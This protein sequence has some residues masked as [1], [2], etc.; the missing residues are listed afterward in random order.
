MEFVCLQSSSKI[1]LQLLPPSSCCSSCSFLPA[2]S[3]G[4]LTRPFLTPSLSVIGDDALFPLS[5]ESCNLSLFLSLPSPR[6]FYFS[7]FAVSYF[8]GI[9]T[10][11]LSLSLSLVLH[12]LPPWIFF[13]VYFRLLFEFFH[14]LSLVLQVNC[15][16]SQDRD[17]EKKDNGLC[18]PLFFFLIN[19]SRFLDLVKCGAHSLS[20]AGTC[21]TPG[22]DRIK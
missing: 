18:F 2:L 4:P 10:L 20:V 3:P 21:V 7:D 5:C 6:S 16:R 8:F 19:F 15:K 17:S 11:P 14:P 1:L 9:F 22:T 13:S 12:C